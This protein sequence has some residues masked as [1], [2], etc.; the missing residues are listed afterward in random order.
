MSEENFA[1]VDNRAIFS[2]LK[3]LLN[4]KSLAQVSAATLDGAITV[5]FGKMEKAST[6]TDR[7][8]MSINQR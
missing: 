6:S 8:F 2:A 5:E 1:G 7:K 3:T 4:C